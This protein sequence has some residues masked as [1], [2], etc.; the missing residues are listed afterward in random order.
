MSALQNVETQ[1]AYKYLQEVEKIA[2]DILTAKDNKLQLANAQNKLRESFRALEH[3][4]DRNTFIQVGCVHIEMPTEECRDKLKQDI[5]EIEEEMNKL[6]K[7]MKENTMKLRDLE[8]EPRL[9]GFSLKPMSVAEAKA[10][11]KGFGLL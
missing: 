9:E 7:T 8:H 11:H 3:V 4:E 5:A 2:Q 6:Q 10:L 1:K